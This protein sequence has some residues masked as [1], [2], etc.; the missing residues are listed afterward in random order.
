[1][2]DKGLNV[3][4]NDEMTKALESKLQEKKKK[5]SLREAIFKHRDSWLFSTAKNL[6]TVYQNYLS[7]LR[8]LEKTERIKK[9]QQERDRHKEEE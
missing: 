9:E 1:M 2:I 8:E 6:K 7:Q 4:L 5:K 3:D